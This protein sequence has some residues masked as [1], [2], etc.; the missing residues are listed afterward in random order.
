MENNKLENISSNLQGIVDAVLSWFKGI[1]HLTYDQIYKAIVAAVLCFLLYFIVTN[2]DQLHNYTVQLFFGLLGVV[3]VLSI[4]HLITDNKKKVKD[5][6]KDHEEIIKY[7]DKEEEKTIDQKHEINDK[8]DAVLQKALYRMKCS[9]IMVHALHNGSKSFSGLPFV[10]FSCIK[11]VINQDIPDY[12]FCADSYQSQLLSLYKFPSL[13]Q[14]NKTMKYSLDEMKDIDF[15]YYAAMY[16]SQDKYSIA[17]IITN[18][19]DRPIGYVTIAWYEKKD[20]AEQSIIDEELD[21]VCSLA[22]AYLIVQ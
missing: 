6:I 8:L 22:K 2:S 19:Y 13:L 5:K 10:K 4:I 16:I 1:K 3:G 7:M 14:K 18:E 20:I 17:Q 15:K 9:R 11:E 21:N 12:D